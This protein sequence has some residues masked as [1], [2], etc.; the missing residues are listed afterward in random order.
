MVEAHAR[1]RWDYYKPFSPTTSLLLRRAARRDRYHQFLLTGINN[2]DPEAYELFMN[3]SLEAPTSQDEG[4]I[5][6][7]V[8][9][10]AEGVA[11]STSP[12]AV[13]TWKD[14][15]ARKQC[16]EWFLDRERF[17]RLVRQVGKWAEYREGWVLEKWHPHPE[18]W[19]Y[20]EVERAVSE[21]KAAE[22]RREAERRAQVAAD[23]VT[24]AA[25]VIEEQRDE[26]S[27]ETA[28]LAL[29]A[30]A[31]R[32][33][34]EYYFRQIRDFFGLRRSGAGDAGSAHELHQV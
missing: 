29:V 32:A 2:D 21:W 15:A 6:F 1:L 12:D 3:A 11:R 20:E 10:F 4:A 16:A 27:H 26:H 5:A 34:F 28:P 7:F 9:L 24:Q 19:Y 33:G 8:H 30:D 31:Q 18:A 17:S 14:E 23:N 22:E 13:E 25:P